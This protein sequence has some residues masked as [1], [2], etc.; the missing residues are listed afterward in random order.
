MLNN[1]L[2]FVEQ[3]CHFC[4][5]TSSFLVDSI[6]IFV[7]QH[8]H[9]YWRASLFLLNNILIFS[10]QHLHFF[11]QHHFCQQKLC[12]SLLQI[13]VILPLGCLKGRLFI[14]KWNKQGPRIEPWGTP[15]TVLLSQDVY[16]CCVKFLLPSWV[17]STNC[18]QL[19]KCD[20]NH[21]FMF[22]LMLYQF[23]LW[24]SVFWIRIQYMLWG[25]VM[26]LPLVDICPWLL[27]YSLWKYEWLFL[28][29][30]FSSIPFVLL[31]KYVCLQNILTC[32]A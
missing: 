3:H 13:T 19:D 24:S 16:L 25:E 2:I 20:L 26:F 8:P 17:I 28:V 11:E 18:E 15:Y 30:S 21:N 31:I 12:L 9:F 22:P 1:I 6:F 14:Y 23:N 4:W 5:T 27:E 29:I 10:G 7:E 32:H